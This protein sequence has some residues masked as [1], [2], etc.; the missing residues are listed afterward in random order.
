MRP[1]KEFPPL[2]SSSDKLWQPVE[3]GDVFLNTLPSASANAEACDATIG[4]DEP[5]KRLRAKQQRT[6]ARERS[7]SMPRKN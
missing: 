4:D 7:G 6:G 2:I 1:V 5:F 3:L